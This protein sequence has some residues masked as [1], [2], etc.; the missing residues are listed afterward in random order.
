ML[1]AHERAPS[2]P[3]ELRLVAKTIVRVPLVAGAKIVSGAAVPSGCRLWALRLPATIEPIAA[4][5]SPTGTDR[6]S[7]GC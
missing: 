4:E 5:R 2:G 6:L 7:G 3:K 1:A